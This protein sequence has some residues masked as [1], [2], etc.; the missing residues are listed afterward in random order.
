[1][2]ISNSSIFELSYGLPGQVVVVKVVVIV[3][4]VVMGGTV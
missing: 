2:S 4:L 3:V 1:M